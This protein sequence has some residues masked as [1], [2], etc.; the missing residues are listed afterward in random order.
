MGYC[1]F[2]E[3]QIEINPPLNK[4]EMNYLSKF[5]QTRRMHREKG[6]YFVDGSGFMGQGHDDDVF[7]FNSPDPSQPG[8]WC[9]WE[10]TE[11]G[12]F[13]EWDGGEKFYDDIQWMRY[14]IDHFLKP[15][16][17]AKESLPFLQC[18]HVM[19]GTIYSQGEEID[20]TWAIHVE[21]NMVEGRKIAITPIGQPMALNQN[22]V[23]DSSFNIDMSMAIDTKLKI[24]GITAEQIHYLNEHYTYQEI[25]VPDSL[26]EKFGGLQH[27]MA[28]ISSDG[29]NLSI[30]LNDDYLIPESVFLIFELLFNPE[31]DLYD[32]NLDMKNCS[33]DGIIEIKNTYYNSSVT[34][35]LAAIAVLNNKLF[36]HDGKMVIIDDKNNRR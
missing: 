15:D 6:P 3:G 31:S 19:N 35:G 29:E 21:N 34:D 14:L 33:V 18:N 13:I 17:L 8:L 20:D 10:I 5:R 1:T 25:S 7:D 22:T 28:S 16:A 30:Y 26:R 27:I 32:H 9:K 36:L 2:Y 4:D 12:R 23:V 11:D 24:S